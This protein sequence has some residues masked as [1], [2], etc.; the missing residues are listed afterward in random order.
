MGTNCGIEGI[1]ANVSDNW[2]VKVRLT[3]AIER[4]KFDLWP[5]LH[6]SIRFR[7]P[8]ITRVDDVTL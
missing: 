1:V 7:G 3:A 5:H 2:L 6:T 8:H 4:H